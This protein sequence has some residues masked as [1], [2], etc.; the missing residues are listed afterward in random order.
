MAKK[1]SRGTRA[2]L[3]AM[4][5][6]YCRLPTTCTRTSLGVALNRLALAD[7]NLAVDAEQVLGSMPAAARRDQERPVHAANS[8][9]FAVAT[10][11]LSSGNA[12]SFSSMTIPLSAGKTGLTS[13]KCR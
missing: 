8:V 4:S 12:Q 9:G 1:R 6:A 10:T 7:E 11:P 13:I 5:N 2:W 3:I